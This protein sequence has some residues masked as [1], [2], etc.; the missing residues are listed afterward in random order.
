M[1]SGLERC[2]AERKRRGHIAGEIYGVVV[3]PA[4][5]W[6]QRCSLPDGLGGVSMGDN[7]QL[8][9]RYIRGNHGVPVDSQYALI[10]LSVLF[11]QDC[12]TFSIGSRGSWLCFIVDST[13]T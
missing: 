2:F 13:W 7:V 4:A 8:Y 10:I 3:A 11:V 5:V 1:H 9:R 6:I 12:Y